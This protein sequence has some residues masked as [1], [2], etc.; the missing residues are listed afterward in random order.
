[1]STSSSGQPSRA[2]ASDTDDGWGSTVT[3]RGAEQPTRVEPM[4]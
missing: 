4:P 2:A 3:A 1:M